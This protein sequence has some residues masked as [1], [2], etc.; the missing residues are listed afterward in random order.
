MSIQL[1]LLEMLDALQ[2]YL[3]EWIGKIH[4]SLEGIV[5]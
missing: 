5:R 3:I 2:A 1:K 4:Y